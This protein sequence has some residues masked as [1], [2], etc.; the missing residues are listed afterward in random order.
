MTAA[1]AFS[2]FAA[3]A[4]VGPGL[5]L[6][7]LLRVRIDPALVLPAGLAA[8]AGCLWLEA[9]TGLRGLFPACIFGLDLAFLMLTLRLPAGQRFALAPGPSLRGALSPFLAFVALLAVTQ[10]GGNR[11]APSGEFLLD[12]LVASDTAFHVGLTR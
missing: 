8:C 7:R 5:A 6:L 1:L 2:T 3:L 11:R 12:P 4:L 9:A 10:Y